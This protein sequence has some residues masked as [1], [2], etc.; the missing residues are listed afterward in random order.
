MEELGTRRTTERVRNGNSPSKDARAAIL[1]DPEIKSSIK[2]ILYD[3][4]CDNKELKEKLHED[5]GIELKASLNPRRKKE[6][7]KNLPRGIEKITPYG[8]AICIAGYEMEYKGMRYENEKFIYQAPKDSDNYPVCLTCQHKENCCPDSFIT[9]RVIN[10]SFDLLPHIDTD[11]PLAF[12][13]LL[14][15]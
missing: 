4:A 1:P 5:F 6:V 15:C 9:G 8:N 14:R 2:R 10:I 3:S 12:H 7:T 11:D 13:I